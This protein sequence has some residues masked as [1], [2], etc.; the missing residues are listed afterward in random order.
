MTKAANK[1]KKQNITILNIFPLSVDLKKLKF[2]KICD[3]VKKKDK[4]TK[5]CPQG[6]P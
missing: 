4:H 2:V 3:I 5:E 1:I 6:L